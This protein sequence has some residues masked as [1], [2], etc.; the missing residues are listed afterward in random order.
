MPQRLT[1]SLGLYLLLTEAVHASIPYTP[2]YIYPPSSQND[3]FAYVLRPSQSTHNDIEFLSLNVSKVE[4]G[5]PSLTDLSSTISFSGNGDTFAFIPTMDSLGNLQVYA[6]DCH[7]S[8]SNGN[9]WT[10]LADN[11][12]TVGN[13][14]WIETS[15]QENEQISG[16]P[17]YLAAG[18]SYAASNDS[19]AS[20]YTF[21]GMCPSSDSSTNNWVSSANYSQT[22]SYL[23]PVIK[24]NQAAYALDAIQS[25]NP[26]V[27]EAGFTFT[28]L[29]SKYATL[30]TGNGLQQQAFVL[31]GG[32]TSNAF[33]NMSS[34]AVFS[35]PEA[36]WTYIDVN[37]PSDTLIEPRSGHSAILSSDGTKI[38][39][40]GGWVGDTDTLAEPQLLVLELGNNV[41]GSSTTGW[42]WTVPA[43]PSQ[44][45]SL[46][47]P[48]MFAHGAAMLP[49]NVMFVTG[50]YLISP[51]NKRSSTF[52]TNSQ[53]YMYNVTSSTW[54]SS[55]TAPIS[56]N[57]QN[58]Q[59]EGPQS[60]PLSSTGQKIGLI[61]G[62]VIAVGLLI[63][64]S[65]LVGQR[66][67][68]R[69]GKDQPHLRRMALGTETSRIWDGGR[70][71]SADGYEYVD[72]ALAPPM[73]EQRVL[74][75]QGCVPDSSYPGT[76]GPG[77][78]PGS[79]WR[80]SG[81]AE[82]ERTGLLFEIPSPTRG[83]R[84]SLQ[85]RPYKN[86]YTGYY[87]DQ[88]GNYGAGLIH[89]ID[90]R[91]EY[92]DVVIDDVDRDEMRRHSQRSALVDPF[93]DPGRSRKTATNEIVE[94]F[95]DVRLLSSGDSERSRS[96][97]PIKSERTHSGLSESSDMSIG[98][99]QRSN[100]GSISKGRGFRDSDI[101]VL[102]PSSRPR[103][104]ATGRLS[105]EKDSSSSE[106]SSS[107]GKNHLRSVVFPFERSHT[108]D[109]FSTGHT[110]TKQSQL[111]GEGLLLGDGQEWATPP[112]SPT[113]PGRS[114]SNKSTSL[115][116]M[117]SVRK[118]LFGSK[119][120]SDPD[121]YSSS[122]P[123]NYS[124]TQQTL[125]SRT[126]PLLTPSPE[127][128]M[129]AS[130]ITHFRRKQGPHD[131]SYAD[132]TNNAN[133]KRASAGSSLSCPPTSDLGLLDMPLHAQQ[134]HDYEDD[135]DEEQE[136]WDVEAAAEGRLVQVTYTVPKERLRVVNA[137][138]GEITDDDRSSRRSGSRELKQGSASVPPGQ[139]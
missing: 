100:I 126:P 43:Q 4:S 25:Q 41:G 30:P 108:A 131:W 105:P 19:S 82:A 53:L 28:P 74:S 70:K 71:G 68:N 81:A 138:V 86:H 13:G 54:V 83:L 79:Q 119:K 113:R 10:F 67:S 98:S 50:G 130:S 48:G 21:G 133:S 18:F 95:E 55:Y 139:N 91:D 5:S 49:G 61:V 120:N 24:S 118:T 137:G 60:G 96:E 76:V 90:E 114:Q 64:L 69:N 123:T 115:S 57:H 78:N 125:S 99:I 39:V 29:A 127:R 12:S 22:M 1:H 44:T 31:I 92:E 132:N 75:V 59:P 47:A 103:S 129:S 11:S 107:R 42:A 66:R 135:E 33:I 84:R 27:A 102:E 134:G 62:L 9:V 8:T 87:D 73:V 110:S 94:P 121:R 26:P 23:H 6:G 124:E 56:Q 7:S 16:G 38:I 88:S 111:E 35:L 20:L 85:S 15:V 2:T 80:Q 97:S 36:T 14:T 40:Y 45:A 51:S 93:V 77:Y 106:R 63:L 128:T 52:A 34:L 116:W 101:P 37:T 3:T 112:E 72:G 117:G 109:S 89:P 122:S 104:A 65:Y 136:E 58:P 46:Q 17:G 32:H